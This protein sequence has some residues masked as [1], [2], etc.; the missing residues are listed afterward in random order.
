[1]T[2]FVLLFAFHWSLS[3]GSYSQQIIIDH[4]NENA[5]TTDL[6]KWPIYFV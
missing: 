6:K 1:M 4:D 3:K 5:N 2:N